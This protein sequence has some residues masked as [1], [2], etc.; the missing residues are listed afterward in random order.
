MSMWTHIVAAIDVETYICSDTIADDVMKLLHNAP[1]ITGSEGNVD[2][3][4]N[5]L[6]GYNLHIAS[7]CTKCNYKGTY[8]DDGNFE[9]SAP[10][11][12]ICPS[13]KYQ[14][15]V[16][17]TII[18]DLRDRTKHQTK[19]AWEKFYKFIKKQINGDG[20]DVRNV[21]CNVQGAI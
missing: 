12:Y 8:N 3:F 10:D 16:I 7:D 21:S 18:G 15:R 9:C 20:F 6:S 13:S 11:G 2:I 14:T 4:V 19:R 17:I 1:Q 5:V